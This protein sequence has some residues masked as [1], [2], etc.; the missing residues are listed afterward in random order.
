MKVVKRLRSQYSSG[1]APLRQT[2]SA[3]EIASCSL[4][5]RNS[6]DLSGLHGADQAQFR[7][8]TGFSV[9]LQNRNRFGKRICTKEMLRSAFDRYAHM[10][11]PRSFSDD[12]SYPSSHLCFSPYSYLTAYARRYFIAYLIDLCRVC[13]GRL[14]NLKGNR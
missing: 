11:N 8:E 2:P 9:F 6:S 3:G 5:H 13:T 10:E 14:P 7:V 12:S 4:Q 1:L